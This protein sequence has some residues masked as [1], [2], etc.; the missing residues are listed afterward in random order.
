MAL[1][2]L[3]GTGAGAVK[4]FIDH[5]NAEIT[6]IINYSQNYGL[7]PDEYTVTFNNEL[8]SYRAVGIDG[9][10]YL[11]LSGV[12]S[13]INNR[14]YY[15][16]N[17][18]KLLYTIPDGTTVAEF[19]QNCYYGAQGDQIDLS[20]QPLKKYNDKIYVAVDYVK[21][22]TKCVI[23][24]YTEPNRV[25]VRN[26]FTEKPMI[27]VNEDSYIRILGGPKS[28]AFRKV[29]AGEN[30]YL[31]DDSYE[32]WTMVASEDGYVGW[33][34][35]KVLG[36]RFA[37]TP[38]AP[39]FEE[40]VYP[41]Q[42]RDHKVKM[43]WHQVMY[44]D[45]NYSFDN[46][47][48]NVTGI[49]TVAPTWFA[50]NDQEGNIRSIAN[51]DYVAKAH[52]RGMEVWALFSNEFPDENGDLQGF[53]GMGIPTNQVLSYTSKRTNAIN[54]II[55]YCQD[56]GIDGI[57]LD[58]ENIISPTEDGTGKSAE[59]FLQFIRELSVACHANNIIFSID[60]YVPLYT[61]HYN[62]AEENAFADYLV[63]MGYDEYYSGGSQ[64]GPNA[65]I[66]FVE[67]GI[68][69]TMSAGVPASKI[70]NGIPFYTRY[71]YTD[72]DTLGCNEAS[73]AEALQYVESHEVTPQWDDS[74]GLNYV[75]YDGSDG[76]TYQM[77]LEDLDAVD[78]K[79]QLITSYDLGGVSCWKIGQEISDVWSVIN[80]YMP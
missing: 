10:V 42:Q 23:D 5:K 51:Y 37:A 50:F 44:E 17:E 60:N 3:V 4:G 66:G 11:E 39:A 16:E 20:Y 41:T 33:L 46:I 31:L 43:V 49:N 14:F 29:E 76:N 38:E 40:F 71:W 30:F 25:V 64:A 32:G 68:K 57:N 2:L 15:D 13:S 28:E 7:S 79:M 6:D 61:Q 55:G 70:I 67:Q 47:F 35:N 58:F 69:D 56:Y 45:A 80:Q 75:T 54:Q 18:E 22:F 34:N 1:I 36:D 52:E 78:R 21:E 77:W 48:Q 24:V 26:D 19:D 12:S 9:T 62:R 73:M 65:S 59:N 8:M 74:L 72:G 63:I 27:A 53:A